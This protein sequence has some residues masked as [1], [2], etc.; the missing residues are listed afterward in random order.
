[1]TPAL[2]SYSISFF[3]LSLSESQPVKHRERE[4][5]EIPSSKVSLSLSTRHFNICRLCCLNAQ[6]N[7][8]KNIKHMHS[9]PV[10]QTYARG[11]AVMQTWHIWFPRMLTFILTLSLSCSL[12][13]AVSLFLCRR[14]IEQEA[15]VKTEKAREGQ[16]RKRRKRKKTAKKRGGGE[17]GLGYSDAFCFL[18]FWAASH[19]CLC[20]CVI[21]IFK[22]LHRGWLLYSLPTS[23]TDCTS[24]H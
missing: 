5:T 19:V 3:F 11:P 12:F 1:M 22:P 16:I 18:Y 9:L 7:P 13:S 6:S 24:A 2:P 8:L 20:V 21:S 23:P 4:I 10:T 17:T 15:K 14:L